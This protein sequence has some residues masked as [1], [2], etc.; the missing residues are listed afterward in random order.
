MMSAYY[1][2]LTKNSLLLNRKAKAIF[3]IFFF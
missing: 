2:L 1:M 3:I